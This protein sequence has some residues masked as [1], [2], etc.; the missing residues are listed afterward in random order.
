[1]MFAALALLLAAA[2]TWFLRV[3]FI[4]V[5]PACRLPP[6]LRAALADVS[7]AVMAAL[8]VTQLAHGEGI[9]GLVLS[10]VLA[11]LVAAGVAWWTRQLAATVVVGVVAAGLLRLAF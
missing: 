3:L 2:A 10:D 4:T 9:G 6:R 11:T 7:P 1:M 8:L 5:V